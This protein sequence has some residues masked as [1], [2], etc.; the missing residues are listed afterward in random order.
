MGRLGAASHCV[1]GKCT[2]GVFVSS[3]VHVRRSPSPAAERLGGC[4]A[5]VP[6]RRRS[7]TRLPRAAAELRVHTDLR[8]GPSTW[9]MAVGFSRSF[10][11]QLVAYPPKQNVH[12][13]CVGV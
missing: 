13:N 2:D 5:A 9:R 7:T 10:I 12:L 1:C 8:T 6:S 4:H 3:L 11:S